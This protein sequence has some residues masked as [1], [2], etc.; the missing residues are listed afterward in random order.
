MLELQAILH[1][2]QLAAYNSSVA[3]IILKLA[4]WFGDPPQDPLQILSQ[5]GEL[6]D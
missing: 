2:H 3:V 1:S 4:Y 5:Y 6:M